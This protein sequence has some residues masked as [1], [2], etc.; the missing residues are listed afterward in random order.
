MPILAKRLCIARSSSVFSETTGS[1]TFFSR[2]S[3]GIGLPMLSYIP[4]KIFELALSFL[5]SEVSTKLDSIISDAPSITAVSAFKAS[6]DAVSDAS[7]ASACDSDATSAVSVSCT[8]SVPKS[9]TA[10]S[11]AV[12]APVSF[13]SPLRSMPDTLSS[14]TTSV[15]AAASAMRFA[16]RSASSSRSPFASAPLNP[17]PRNTGRATDFLVGSARCD[18]LFRIFG[19]SSIPSKRSG[20]FSSSSA[21]ASSSLANAFQIL[22]DDSSGGSSVFCWRQT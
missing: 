6:S 7:V 2:N 15:C 20:A 19:E 5:S 22:S 9:S 16:S 11:S 3:S 14:I 10:S 12:S 17:L 18:V 1:S 4:L 8:P 13:S 21:A